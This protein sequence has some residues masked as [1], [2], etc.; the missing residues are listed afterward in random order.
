MGKEDEAGPE[1]Y[2]L[3]WGRVPWAPAQSG[4]RSPEFPWGHYT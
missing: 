4:D 3:P 1:G 2:V